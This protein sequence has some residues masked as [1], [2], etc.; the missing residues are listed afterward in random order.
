MW[1]IH[2]MKEYYT[3]RSFEIKFG[4]VVCLFSFV[5]WLIGIVCFI[6]F[7]SFGIVVCLFFLW[8]TRSLNTGNFVLVNIRKNIVLLRHDIATYTGL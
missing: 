4:I 1:Q 2:L 3:Q 8:G 7:C 6:L 5:V